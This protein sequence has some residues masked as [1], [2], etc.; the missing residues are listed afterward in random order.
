[1][2]AS[3]APLLLRWAQGLR[4]TRAAS[5]C[6]RRAAAT[7][8]TRRKGCAFL[9]NASCRLAWSLTAVRTQ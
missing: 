5:S 9:A 7:Q 4:L 1:M 2:A 8:R 6:R 3:G